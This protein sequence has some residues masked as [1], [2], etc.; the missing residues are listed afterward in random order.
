MYFIVIIFI[1]LLNPSL[2]G[3]FSKELVC[4]KQNNHL[5]T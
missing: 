5:K 2:K 1:L 4:P 3:A